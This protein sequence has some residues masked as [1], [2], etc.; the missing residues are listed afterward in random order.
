MWTLLVGMTFFSLAYNVKCTC[1]VFNN[2]MLLLNK[3]KSCWNNV[4]IEY[5]CDGKNDDEVFTLF[6]LSTPLI[7]LFKFFYKIKF[8]I[9]ST[10]IDIV[11]FYFNFYVCVLL[12][13][14]LGRTTWTQ[15][16]CGERGWCQML[17]CI[18]LMLL[19]PVE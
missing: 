4:T 18:L 13:R 1:K 14:Q 19:F 10:P 6:F 12:A 15:N 9:L 7:I 5:L 17:F 16:W 3:M 11:E 8:S 2:C